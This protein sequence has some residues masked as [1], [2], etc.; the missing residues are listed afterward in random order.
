MHTARA[1]LFATLLMSTPVAAFAQEEEDVSSST[2]TTALEDAM[3]RYLSR[4]THYP[5][6]GNVRLV[7][8][9]Q[10][11]YYD[12]MIDPHV[13]SE[14]A[15]YILRV[16]E[17]DCPGNVHAFIHNRN[18]E[19]QHPRVGRILVIEDDDAIALLDSL[20]QVPA[21]AELVPDPRL[22]DTKTPP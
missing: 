13:L 11:T 21:L 14:Y 22:T 19:L 2:D 6:G 9:L 7:A 10:C 17:G 3:D 1:L 12:I 5:A 16:L 20:P 15:G 4:T 8:P 18:P